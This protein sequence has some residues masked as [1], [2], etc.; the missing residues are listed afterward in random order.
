MKALS[1]K[2]LQGGTL[3][4]ELIDLDGSVEELRHLCPDYQCK[5]SARSF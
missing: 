1:G 2:E 3:D 5:A 4:L